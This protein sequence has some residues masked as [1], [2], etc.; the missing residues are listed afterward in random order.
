MSRSEILKFRCSPEELDTLQAQLK[1]GQNLSELIRQ[2]LGLDHTEVKHGVVDPP[3]KKLEGVRQTPGL[4]CSPKHTGAGFSANNNPLVTVTKPLSADNQGAD[5]GP[6]VVATESNKIAGFMQNCAMQKAPKKKR[7][8]G[9]LLLA[10]FI[11]VLL[12]LGYFIIQVQMY[13]MTGG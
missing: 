5:I 7:S 3:T 6:L 8:W 2:R 1:D 11:L 12:V 10:G 4:T 9:W 13:F